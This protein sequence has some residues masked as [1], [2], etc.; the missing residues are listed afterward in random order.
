MPGDGHLRSGLI[1]WRRVS[2]L[3]F[4]IS[5]HRW[6][7]ALDGRSRMWLKHLHASFQR[8][9]VTMAIIW[10]QKAP[11]DETDDVRD[12]NAHRGADALENDAQSPALCNSHP[13]LMTFRSVEDG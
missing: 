13:A 7:R 3:V 1:S 4:M 8:A 6:Y 5:P 2:T 12:Q 9:C 11:G 10:V